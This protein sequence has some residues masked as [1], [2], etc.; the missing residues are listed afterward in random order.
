[1]LWLINDG[2][3]YAMDSTQLSSQ[4]RGKK[5]DDYWITFANSPEYW[6]HS[7]FGGDP[8]NNESAVHEIWH[9]FK[10]KSRAAIE[11]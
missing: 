9:I 6:K 7:S 2:E 10:A 8:P 4:K 11:K 1:M 5:S 3:N